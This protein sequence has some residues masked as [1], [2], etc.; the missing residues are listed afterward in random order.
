M[1]KPNLVVIAGCNGSGKSTFAKQLVPRNI[2]PFDADKRK[3]EI[4]DEF[5]FDFEFRD[6]MSWNKTQEEF[7]NSVNKAINNK[8][9]FAYETNFN[10]APLHWIK[11]FKRSGFSIHLQF[12][13]LRSI[14]LAKQ[15]VAIRVQSGGHYVPD[16]EVAKRYVEGFKNLD[17]YFSHFDT[18]MIL[19][20]SAE[21]KKPTTIFSNG[22]DGEVKVKRNIPKYFKKNCPKLYE[23]ISNSN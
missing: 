15:R 19:E 5:E 13:S 6:K 22:M 17:K 11:L 4:Y 20:A 21:D 12:F 3:K 18:L 16:L 7:E 9:D 10:Q 23:F 2:V 8:I 1:S 14:S